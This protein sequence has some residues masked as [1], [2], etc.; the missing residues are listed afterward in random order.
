MVPVDQLNSVPDVQTVENRFEPCREGHLYP[1]LIGIE[2]RTRRPEGL[3]TGNGGDRREWK[4]GVRQIITA[5]GC[6]LVQEI[7]RQKKWK[8]TTPFLAPQ[9]VFHLPI[10]TFNTSPLFIRHE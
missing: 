2:R 5:K 8:R 3:Y 6:N 7:M 4:R 10:F 1:Q 9:F